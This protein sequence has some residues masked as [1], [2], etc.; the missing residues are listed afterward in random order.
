MAVMAIA[1]GRRSLLTARCREAMH[2]QAVTLRLL[3]MTLGAI[4][5]LGGDIVIG[6]FGRNIGM[7]TCARIS[8][9]N[10]SRKFRHIHK[11]G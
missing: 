9:V 8:A 6:M 11:K 10:R 3:F 5:W 4:D 7:A 1:A 2:A